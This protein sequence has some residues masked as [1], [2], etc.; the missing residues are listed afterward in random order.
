MIGSLA[1]GLVGVIVDEVAAQGGR[2]I[3]Q[4]RDGVAT[5]QQ[6][7]QQQQQYQQQR[8][9]HQQQ[10]PPGPLA[11]FVESITLFFNRAVGAVF[12]VR[13]YTRMKLR[14]CRSNWRTRYL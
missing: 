1:Q 3:Q 11:S 10:L 4:Q 14:T 13:T 5:Y 2:R 12:A 8:Q 6:Q 9:Q 7:M